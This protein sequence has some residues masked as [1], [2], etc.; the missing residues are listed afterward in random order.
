[1]GP[2]SVYMYNYASEKRGRGGEREERERER[3]RNWCQYPIGILK[4]I[5]TKPHPLT[6]FAMV[7]T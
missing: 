3:E 2:V 7:T 1:M 4:F 5:V 6:S